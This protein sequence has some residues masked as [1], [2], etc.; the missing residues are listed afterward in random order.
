MI[1][2]FS[3]FI[4]LSKVCCNSTEI[5]TPLTEADAFKDGASKFDFSK[6]SLSSNQMKILFNDNT[7]SLIRQ[8]IDQSSGIISKFGRDLIDK[9]SSKNS[10][11]LYLLEYFTKFNDSNPPKKFEQISSED[12]D[13][14]SFF[15]LFSTYLIL[16]QLFQLI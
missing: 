16:F 5:T 3:T 15:S 10:D 7:N 14:L 6:I 8:I 9:T 12:L 13:P 4:E 11:Y 1:H 2:Q